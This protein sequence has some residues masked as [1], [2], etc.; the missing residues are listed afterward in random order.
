M[1]NDP[2]LQPN[3]AINRWIQGILLFTFELVHVPAKNHKGPDALSR[4]TL[5][6]GEKAVSDDDSWLDGIALLTFFPTLKTT[7]NPIDPD[8][9]TTNLQVPITSSLSFATRIAQEEM[10]KDIEHFLRTLET[11]RFPDLQKKRRFLAKATDFIVKEE[12]LFK[13]NGNRPPLLVIFTPERKLSILRQAHEELGHRGFQAVYEILR[14]RFFWPHMRADVHHHVQSCH[15]CQVRSLKRTEIPLTISTPIKLFSKIYVDIM[16]MPTSIDKKVCIVAA[17]DDLS[18]VCEVKALS[19]KTAEELRVF[20]WEQIYCRYGA[21]EHVITDNGS[22]IKGVFKVLLKRLG[23]PHIKI[24]PYNHHANGVVERGHFTIRESL[25]KACQTAGIPINRWPEKLA[26]VAFADRITISR[27]TG[28]LPYQLLH[29][30]D[31]LLPLDLAEA[32]FLVEGFHAGMSHSELVALRTRQLSKHP[33]DV[34]RAARILKKAR[35]ESKEQ[36]EKRFIHR[37]SRDTYEKGEIV[38]VRNTQI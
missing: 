29:G 18:G 6:E 21:P 35:F 25:V 13:R 3:A 27:T 33:D 7:K 38:L 37:L 12:K 1:L 14:H 15:E 36:F 22:E 8:R 5:A 9:P 30:T 26:E 31:P 10:L 19:N 4:R 34:A 16:H 17:R 23:I 24:T 11:P 20:F 32:T 2:D 28:F